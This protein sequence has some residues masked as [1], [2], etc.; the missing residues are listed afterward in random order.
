VR[1][2]LSVTILGL[3]GLL[4]LPVDGATVDRLT[5][6]KHQDTYEIEFDAEVKAPAE[7]VYRVLSDP[8]LLS[9]LSPTI[10]SV[11]IEQTENGAPKRVRYV[12]RGCFLF[13][14]KEVVEV[15]E[16]IES[17]EHTISARIVPG[18]SD[19]KGGSYVWRLTTAGDRTLLSYHAKRTP[20]F[21][22]PPLI[23]PWIMERIIRTHA[24]T[25][26]E[27]METLAVEATPR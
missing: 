6:S 25:S 13:F 21:W 20:D 26:V 27:R 15:D 19:F 8:M 18:Q 24:E 11:R 1:A 2:A 22:I 17:N 9:R 3:V 23:G 4:D 12:M 14:C 16:I 7:G 5:V 10:T